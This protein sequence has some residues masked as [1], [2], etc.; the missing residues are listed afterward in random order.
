MST[1]RVLIPLANDAKKDESRKVYSTVGSVTVLRVTEAWMWQQEHL[2]TASH[3]WAFGAGTAEA[4]RRG[5]TL[6]ALSEAQLRTLDDR[7]A[8]VAN[9]YDKNFYG[10]LEEIKWCINAVSETCVPGTVEFVFFGPSWHLLR[11]R[12]IWLLFFQSTWGSARFVATSDPAS[13]E[14]GH[15]VRAWGRIAL[16]RLG[17]L[18]SR[19][20]V[21]YPP[22]RDTYGIEC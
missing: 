17:V 8:V 20:Q 16:C 6:A 5:Q 11:V 4:Y 3:V 10:T 13:F 18:K 19:D 7:A 21:P 12:F 15:E 14:L 2:P 1:L 9:H 22:V